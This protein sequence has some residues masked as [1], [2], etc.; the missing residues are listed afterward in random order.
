[1]TICDLVEEN[2]AKAKQSYSFVKVTKNYR[3]IIQAPDIDAVLIATPV[4]S[5]FTIAHEALENGKHIFVEKPLTLSVKQAQ[6]LVDLAQ[7]KNLKIMVDH[8]FLF[9][10]AIKCI[11]K[12]LA[13]ETLGKLF[14]YDSTRIRLGAFQDDVDVIWDLAPHDFSI[15]D[16]LIAEKPL[17]I[18]SQGVDH[19]ETGRINLASIFLY[20]PDNFVA[21]IR[22]NWLAPLKIRQIL[23]S[24]QKKMLVWDD[25]EADEKIKIYDAGVD[26]KTSDNRRDILVDYRVGD[27]LSPHIVRKEALE[28]EAKYFVHCIN[29]G[30]E[31]LNN[32]QA[33]LRVVKWLEASDLSL[34]N[35]GQR[36]AL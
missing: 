32:G 19:F 34:K 8:T 2:L 14:Y 21:Q 15:L 22:L 3:D 26:I 11:K 33:G 1:M 28:E 29:T 18:S 25:V 35:G 13:E 4:S 5:H 9:T 10:G 31:P 23:L 17:A 16:Y 20:Y 36:I 30:T 7:R 24:G 27:V 6:I 12:V